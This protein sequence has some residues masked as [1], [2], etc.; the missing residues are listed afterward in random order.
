MAQ[1]RHG[2][3]SYDN[4]NRAF[5]VARVN[6]SCIDSVSEHK[7]EVIGRLIRGES[8][9]DAKREDD[10]NLSNASN[11]ESICPN[12]TKGVTVDNNSKCDEGK[13]L[14]D[15]EHATKPAL[16][17]KK[18]GNMSRKKLDVNATT[19]VMVVGNLLIWKKPAKACRKSLC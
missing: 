1:H 4:V 15:A 19:D 17:L 2:N 14:T 16:A 5:V 3:H 10:D 7:R 18:L 6:H 11:D 8:L 9:N 12:R 13:E